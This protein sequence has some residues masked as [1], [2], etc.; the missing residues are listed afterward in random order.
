M[1]VQVAPASRDLYTPNPAYE[2]RAINTSPVPTHTTLGSEGA[3][4]MEPIEVVAS[5]SKIGVHVVPL[6]IDFH[7]PPMPA[8]A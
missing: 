4:A 7:T 3:T 2:L 5:L 6:L 1:F 8:P